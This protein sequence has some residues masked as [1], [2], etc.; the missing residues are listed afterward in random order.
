M[1]PTAEALL[2]LQPEVIVEI[3][4][5]GMMSV[6]Q[7]PYHQSAWQALSAI[8]AVRMGRVHLLAGTDLIVP[9]PRL[10][11]GTE[12]LARILHPDAF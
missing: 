3:Q 12:K 2:A 4:A 8:P 9:G 5:E 11:A 6:T 10:A 7:S 1:Q